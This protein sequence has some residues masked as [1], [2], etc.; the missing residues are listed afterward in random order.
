MLMSGAGKKSTWL[1]P[2]PAAAAGA[3]AEPAPGYAS[4]TPYAQP[5]LSVQPMAP[6][7]YG[8]GG[9]MPQQMQQPAAYAAQPPAPQPMQP[10][11]PQ[12]MQP[13][14]AP[15]Q[16]QP[17]PQ[18]PQPAPLPPGWDHYPDPASGRTVFRNLATG[19]T[20]WEDPRPPLPH[21]APSQ[22]SPGLIPAAVPAFPAAPAAAAPAAAASATPLSF[23][24][25]RFAFSN[26]PSKSR[27][28]EALRAAASRAT[29]ASSS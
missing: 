26:S 22:P 25:F 28:G 18:Q 3:P 11:A 6:G 9:A 23:A 29:I 10:A 17:A 1:A 20:T 2:K 12:P 5:D 4:G 7:P 8:A 16:P 13:Q 21:P 15:Q 24:A 27:S 14:P 19:Q